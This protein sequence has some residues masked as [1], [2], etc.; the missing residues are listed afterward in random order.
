MRVREYF[1]TAIEKGNEKAGGIV[2]D[3]SPDLG[4]SIYWFVHNEKDCTV[5]TKFILALTQLPNF[6]YYNPFFSL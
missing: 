6:F 4:L 3:V 2:K 1:E 5:L